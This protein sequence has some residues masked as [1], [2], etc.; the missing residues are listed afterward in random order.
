VLST[1]VG[2]PANVYRVDITI[3]TASDYAGVVA[4]SISDARAELTTT[5]RLRNL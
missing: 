4:N 1:P 3:Q 2:T 5:V